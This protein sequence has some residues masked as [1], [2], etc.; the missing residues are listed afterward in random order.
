M[1][2]WDAFYPYLLVD[3]PGVADP[4]ADNRLCLAAREFCQRTM[5]W[6][7]WQDP[8]TPTVSGASYDFDIPSG[9]ELVRIARATIGAEPI[10]GHDLKVLT[11]DHIPGRWHPMVHKQYIRHDLGNDSFT[12]FVTTVGEPV[13]LLLV[14]KPKLGATSCADVLADRYADAIALKAKALVQMTPG[15]AFTNPALAAENNRL[16]EAAVMDAANESFRRRT[17]KR[18]A[19]TPI[20]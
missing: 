11:D 7:E 18:T 4:L 13:N 10:D 19:K 16:F 15:Y 14:F 6:S 12:L 20:A 3:L 1:K 8:I 5:A 2:T 9:A 17:Q